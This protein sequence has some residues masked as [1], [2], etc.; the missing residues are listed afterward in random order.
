MRKGDKVIGRQLTE[1][2]GQ[3]AQYSKG[4]HESS[5]ATGSVTLMKDNFE[6]PK[7]MLHDCL[8]ELEKQGCVKDISWP[9]DEPWATVEITDYGV[10]LLSPEPGN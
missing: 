7:D 9:H 2:L 6:M 5:G 3:L 1:V 10:S 4:E 8:R